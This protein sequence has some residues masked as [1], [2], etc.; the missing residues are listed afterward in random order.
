MEATQTL[1]ALVQDLDTDS[2]YFFVEATTLLTEH[3]RISLEMRG[4]INQPKDD[5]LIDLQDDDHV[6]LELA[7]HF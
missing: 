4:F 5:L 7:Y 2:R 6:Q 3:W 1:V